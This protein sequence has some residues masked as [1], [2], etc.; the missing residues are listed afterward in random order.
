MPTNNQLKQNHGEDHHNDFP[1]D[2]GKELDSEIDSVYSILK[3][4]GNTSSNNKNSNNNNGSDDDDNC[5]LSTFD[6]IVSGVEIA[7][8]KETLQ[9][10][11]NFQDDDDT[12]TSLNQS[13]PTDSSI[14]AIWAIIQFAARLF[15]KLW[16]HALRL[17]FA[18]N[19]S[20]VLELKP[21][22]NDASSGGLNNDNN[23]NN[24]SDDDNGSL[25]S[26]SLS[27]DDIDDYSISDKKLAFQEATLCKKQDQTGKRTPL[28]PPQ[29]NI[30]IPF[31]S[32]LRIR[33]H[34]PF[35]QP[36]GSTN[37]GTMPYA[38][39][40]PKTRV[41]YL[42]L[43]NFLAMMRAPTTTTTTAVTMMMMEVSPLQVSLLMKLMMIIPPHMTAMMWM[44]ILISL[45]LP[46]PQPS[47]LPKNLTSP[48]YHRPRMNG[49]I[50]KAPNKTTLLGFLVKA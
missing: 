31:P 5:S 17:K 14:N 3:L 48:I 44:R 21:F 43:W 36:P 9:D 11:P 32:L 39:N 38:S 15:N 27:S 22:G 46:N 29:K 50:G 20:G 4:L 35:L 1:F 33:R 18:K 42:N 13:P 47:P 24:S 49:P 40:L 6:H 16:C 10:S 2:R 37:N 26:E 12:K 34:C 28:Y 8:Q 30:L 7:F 23:N 19:P 25:S 41:L 45:L